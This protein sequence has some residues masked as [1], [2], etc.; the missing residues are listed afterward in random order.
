MSDR[1]WMTRTWIEEVEL[2]ARRD[3]LNDSKA[4][5]LEQ[6]REQRREALW[7]EERGERP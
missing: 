4:M 2:D 6:I 7:H 3:Y 1:D 5:R